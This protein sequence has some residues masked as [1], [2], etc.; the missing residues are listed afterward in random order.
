MGKRESVGKTSEPR[1]YAVEVRN[2]WHWQGTLKSLNL[3]ESASDFI[4]K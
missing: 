3:S 2:K 1:G 4:H